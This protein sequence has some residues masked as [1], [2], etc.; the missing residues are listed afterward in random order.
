MWPFAAFLPWIDIPASLS[1]AVDSVAGPTISVQPLTD[2]VHFLT[3]CDVMVPGSQP[4]SYLTPLPC[5]PMVTHAD[6]KLVSAL[7]PAKGGEE[8]VAYA[9]GLGQT[10]PPLTLGA[11]AATG[12]PTLTV[13]AID[14][15]YRT[16]ALAT[17]PAG[18][19]FPG[20]GVG[21]PT[22]AFTGATPGFVGLYQINFIV[23]PPP[24]G[25]TACVDTTAIIPF[26]NAVQSNLTVSVGSAF[27]FDGAGICVQPAQ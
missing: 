6:G 4:R 17:R 23:P 2:Q 24:P 15:N 7:S 25:L 11:P 27:S 12:A 20:T 22:P 26:T 16:N 14:F 19:S 8:V 18:P 13:F 1:V 21:F 5:P 3:N 10:N 9:V